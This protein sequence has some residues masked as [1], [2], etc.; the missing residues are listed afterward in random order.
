MAYRKTFH[1]LN[2]RKTV[3]KSSNKIS[4][5]ED[6]QIY[7]QPQANN[8]EILIEQENCRR[9]E[10]NNGTHDQ[11]KITTKVEKNKMEIDF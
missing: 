10:N 4:K 11:G 8:Q 3:D 1:I 5:P 9:A 7:Y 6:A 2:I